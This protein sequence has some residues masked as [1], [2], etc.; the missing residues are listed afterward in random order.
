M[1]KYAQGTG[2]V[3][4]VGL[5]SDVEIPLPRDAQ[6]FV[7][8]RDGRCVPTTASVLQPCQAHSI[9]RFMFMLE[10]LA[11]SFRCCAPVG[12]ILG[13]DAAVVGPVLSGC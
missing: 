12:S 6:G 4:T 3:N 10:H 1:R 7:L 11:Q 13:A 5:V 2:P 9:R 8:N